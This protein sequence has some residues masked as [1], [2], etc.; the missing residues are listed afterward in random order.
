MEA[1]I[2]GGKDAS[3]S[4]NASCGIKNK[5]GKKAE[6]SA[7]KESPGKPGVGGCLA[8]KVRWGRGG[9]GGK[10]EDRWSFTNKRIGKGGSVE[11]TV[12]KGRW[13]KRR[14]N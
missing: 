1:K 4:K 13:K 5:K 11:V 10:G 8:K 2:G 3:K 7:P 12:T 6:K 14:L 9:H